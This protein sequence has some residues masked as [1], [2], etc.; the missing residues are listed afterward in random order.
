MKYFI[1]TEF[2]EGKQK[3]SFPISLFRKEKPNTIDL[4]SIG[5]VAENGKEYYAISKDFNLKE[6]WNR[7][8]LVQESGDMRNIFPN[9]KK[10]Y[11]VRENVLKPIYYELIGKDIGFHDYDRFFTYESLKNLIHKKGKTNKEIATEIQEFVYGF[12]IK[13][14]DENEFQKETTQKLI[15]NFKEPIEF[16]AYYADYDWVVFCWLFGKMMDLPDGFPMYCK[17]LKQMLDDKAS[18][19]TKNDKVFIENGYSK[20]EDAIKLL[21]IHVHY[22]KQDSS[23]S[24]NA[25]EDARWNKQL[26]EFLTQL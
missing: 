23:K 22:P 12:A 5:I 13:G 7:Y 26:F 20:I 24:H 17:D 16:Y 21:K 15:S 18:W 19:I 4:I 14:Y 9:G 8:D 10:L 3:E 11:W 2:L 25:I 6:A 1:D